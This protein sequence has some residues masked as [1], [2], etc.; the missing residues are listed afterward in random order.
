ME[1]PAKTSR[2]ASPVPVNSNEGSKSHLSHDQKSQHQNF[3]TF[4]SQ[5][6]LLIFS[7]TETCNYPQ[8]DG[9]SYV[10]LVKML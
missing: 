7:P 3:Q 4:L 9:H 5:V 1:A 8:K 10:S 2:S 6:S